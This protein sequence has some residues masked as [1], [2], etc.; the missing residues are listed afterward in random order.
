[1]N[2]KTTLV[3]IVLLAVLG[4]FAYVMKDRS[5]SYSEM[6]AKRDADINGVSLFAADQLKSNWVDTLTLTQDGKHA[7][8]SRVNDQWRQVEPVDFSLSKTNVLEVIDTILD[9]KYTDVFTPGKN[10]YPTLDKLGLAPAAATITL[11]G[12]GE[13]V[14]SY[15]INVGRT[16]VGGKLYVTRDNDPKVYVVPDALANELTNQ[17]T[18]RWRITSLPAPGENQAQSITLI[19]HSQD[20]SSNTAADIELQKTNGSWQLKSPDQ[21]RVDRQAVASLLNTAKATTIQKFIADAPADLSVFGLTS[22][23]VKLII[24]SSRPS[25][26]KDAA[27]KIQTVTQTLSIGAPADLQNNTYYATWTQSESQSQPAKSDKTGPSVFTLDKAAFTHFTQSVDTLR[28]PLLTPLE[29]GQV[30][31]ITLNH[32][33]T[34]AAFSRSAKGWEYDKPA[35][36]K[37]IDNKQPD[38]LADD[39]SVSK[40]VAAITSTKATRFVPRIAEAGPAFATVKLTSTGQATPDVLRIWT[41]NEKDD[42]GQSQWLVVRNDEPVGRVVLASQ[43][44]GVVLPA[45]Q[46]RDRELADLPAQKINHIVISQPDGSKIDLTRTLPTPLATTNVTKQGETQTT[47]RDTAGPWTRTQ[48]VAATDAGSD[49]AASMIDPTLPAAIVSGVSPLRVAAWRAPD[50]AIELKAGSHAYDLVVST[51]EG[52]SIHLKMDEHGH[53]QLDGQAQ[54]F[55]LAPALRDAIKASYGK[56]VK[57]TDK[58]VD[59]TK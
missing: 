26:D 12:S 44:A 9:L 20:N 50:A 53:A 47:P 22:P 31:Q 17:P 33:N 19:N 40:L 29:Q 30:K 38:Y 49:A 43:L 59:M 11:A 8:L 3:L 4:G 37:Q 7:K 27:Q 6:Q 45:W 10:D 34:S 25:L 1:M 46:F 13:H 35:D 15:Q 23:A 52:K 58:D 39:S 42:K 41:V 51:S 14:F 18:H 24:V 56:P 48:D 54:T 28:D 5:P 2:F 57:A 55:E 21:G 36:L 16:I 32:Q